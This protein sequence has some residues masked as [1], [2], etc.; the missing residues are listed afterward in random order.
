[1]TGSKKL[2]IL[3]IDNYDSFVFNL[4]DEFEKRGCNV[5]V[6]RNDISYE[7]ALELFNALPE[8]SLIV[9]SPGPGTPDD[10][11]CC[12]ELVKKAGDSVPFFGVCLGQQIMTQALN[13]EVVFAEEIVHGKASLVDVSNS[14]DLFGNMASKISV[15][16]YHSLKC[17]VQSSEFDTVAEYGDIPMAVVHRTRPLLGVQFHPESVLS[18]DG[19]KII[20]NVIKWAKD[21]SKS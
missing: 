8:P 20:E 21:K 19:G 1:M 16:R 15:G 11:G 9:L 12:L 10:A 2:N 6:W 13:G 17:N 4:V 5:Q 18:P 7:K 3:F 14:S